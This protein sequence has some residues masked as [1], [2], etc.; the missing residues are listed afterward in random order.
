MAN[1]KDLLL[2]KRVRELSR[3]ANRSGYVVRLELET[4]PGMTPDEYGML[5]GEQASCGHPRFRVEVV[6]GRRCV[7]EEEHRS[8]L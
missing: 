7:V 8:A 3:E 5:L 4:P 1:S 2:R 6:E